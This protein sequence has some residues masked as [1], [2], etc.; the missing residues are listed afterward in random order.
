MNIS[1]YRIVQPKLKQEKLRILHISDSHFGRK[2]S[3]EEKTQRMTDILQAAESLCPDVI[4]MTGDLVSRT[5]DEEALKFGYMLLRMLSRKAPVLYVFGNHETTLPEE[6]RI[7]LLQK[8]GEL[9]IHILNN[10]S[11]NLCGVDFFGYVLPNSC[12]KNENGSYRR[13][14]KCSWTEIRK[15]IGE[16]G[17]APCVLLAHNPMGLDAYADW[18]AD[19]VLSGHVHGGIVRLPLIGGILSPERRFFPKYTKGCYEHE[20]TKMVVSA[21]IGKLRFFNPAEV[22]CVDLV[23][24][25]AECLK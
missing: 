23:R 3:F 9:D 5:A 12:Y 7:A 8:I 20:G 2:A 4:A 21:G 16:R 14:E 11:V 6:M 25:G 18:G 10:A 1:K 22:V 17:D 13:L 15:A 19:V 24:D